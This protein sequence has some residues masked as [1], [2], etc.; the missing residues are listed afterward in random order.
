MDINGADARCHCSQKINRERSLI[1]VDFW[2][3]DFS[4]TFSVPLLAQGDDLCSGKHDRLCGRR[5]VLSGFDCCSVF[6]GRSASD[7]Y[8]KLPFA[9][10]QSRQPEEAAWTWRLIFS[11]SLKRCRGR[12]L[13]W[14]TQFEHAGLDYNHTQVHPLLL[15]ISLSLFYFSISL[16]FVI[17]LF[18]PHK[19]D[20]R[21][22]EWWIKICMVVRL[23]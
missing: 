7:F 14:L 9:S 15:S 16:L 2:G 12:Q 10:F 23:Q 1:S 8:V 6:W 20:H 17:F 4:G 5:V 13:D 19:W 11:W 18:S 22:A 21:R 3:C